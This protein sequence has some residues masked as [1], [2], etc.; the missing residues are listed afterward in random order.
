M[1]YFLIPGV[2]I[3][4]SG[5]PS[6]LALTLFGGGVIGVRRGRGAWRADALDTRLA[7]TLFC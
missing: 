6:R 2:E 5:V 1:S 3:L 4:F 7:L